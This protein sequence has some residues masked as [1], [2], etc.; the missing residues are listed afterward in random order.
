M[1]VLRKRK[2]CQKERYGLD[3]LNFQEIHLSLSLL[4]VRDS[5]STCSN[6][7]TEIRHTLMIQRQWVYNYVKPLVFMLRQSHMYLQSISHHALIYSAEL[8]LSIIIGVQVAIKY[9]II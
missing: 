5:I 2:G 7:Q 8:D 3:W 1:T 9:G 4:N 6:H